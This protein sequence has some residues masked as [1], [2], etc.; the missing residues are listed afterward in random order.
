MSFTLNKVA[1]KIIFTLPCLFLLQ[2]CNASPTQENKPV[3]KNS[4]QQ[5]QWQ[6]ATIKFMEFEGG[7]FGIVTDDGEKLLPMNL[8]K[9]FHQIGAKVKVQGHLITDMMTIQ[10]WGT[11]F[12][13]TKI[14]LIKAGKPKADNNQQ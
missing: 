2:A 5:A 8:A 4:E 6:S 1:L 7:F 10:Q 3:V 14:E 11:P 9:E 12:N 13:I